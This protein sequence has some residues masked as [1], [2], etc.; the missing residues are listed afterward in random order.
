MQFVYMTLLT[1]FCSG[2]SWYWW[3]RFRKERNSWF[4]HI[5]RF[6]TLY[7]GIVSIALYIAYLLVGIT[8]WI[9]GF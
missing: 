2:G 1:L 6:I 5:A 8:R 9:W 7:V 4:I 3:K